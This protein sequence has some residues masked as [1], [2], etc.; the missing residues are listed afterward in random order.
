MRHSEFQLKTP[1]KSSKRPSNEAQP[2]QNSRAPQ[3]SV[4]L[5]SDAY[6]C[7]DRG[8]RREGRGDRGERRERRE[9]SENSDKGK[10]EKE[11]GGPGASLARHCQQAGEAQC[12]CTD[13]TGSVRTQSLHLLYF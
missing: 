13:M 12:L 6:P 11:E 8:G 3:S 4:E 1:K 10:R 7:T 2:Q 9:E 5:D